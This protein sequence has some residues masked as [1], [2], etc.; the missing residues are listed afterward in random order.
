MKYGEKR[1]DFVLQPVSA[2]AAAKS[3]DEEWWTE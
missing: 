1:E 3:N 2:K